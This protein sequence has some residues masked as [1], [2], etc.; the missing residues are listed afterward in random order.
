MEII[1]KQIKRSPDRQNILFYVSISLL[2]VV[3]LIQLG[4]SFMV[5]KSETALLELE[6]TLAEK[7]T[8]EEKRTE[9]MVFDFQQKIRD[10]PLIINRHV[11][12]S[13][14]FRFFEELCHPDVWFS[15]AKINLLN[16]SIRVSG[17]ALD[18]STL[19]QQLAIF[20]EESLITEVSLSSLSINKKGGALFDFD[21]VFN[22]QTVK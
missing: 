15:K 11:Y 17:N 3:I 13:R 5:N 1:P 19:D 4:L 16:N 7:K 12:P 10:F 22:P 20:K 14:L 6:I 2:V 18:F 21:L 8:E 9:A